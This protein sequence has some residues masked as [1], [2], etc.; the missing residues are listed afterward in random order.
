MQTSHLILDRIKLFCVEYSYKKVK[1]SE[2]DQDELEDFGTPVCHNKESYIIF[3]YFDY[4]NNIVYLRYSDPEIELLYITEPIK[5]EFNKLSLP[6]IL[7]Q[8]GGQQK[9]L[10]ENQNLL[11]ITYPTHKDSI[12]T[13]EKVTD[14]LFIKSFIES[15]N[16]LKEEL[17]RYRISEESVEDLSKQLLNYI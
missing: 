10:V 16:C 14:S 5:I 2:L 11:Y 17:S 9:L 8:C 13:V 12:G 3:E 6:I 7:I 1:R 4:E 15:G